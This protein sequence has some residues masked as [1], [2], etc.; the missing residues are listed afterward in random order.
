MLYT[1][2]IPDH[3]PELD[4]PGLLQLEDAPGVGCPPVASGPSHEHR[5][6]GEFSWRCSAHLGRGGRLQPDAVHSPGCAAWRVC[7]GQAGAHPA[8]APLGPRREASVWV[9]AQVAR[10]HGSHA[11]KRRGQK[12]QERK[13]RRFAFAAVGPK[14]IY[15][16]MCWD[17]GWVSPWDVCGFGRIYGRSRLF[18]QSWVTVSLRW[19]R[20]ENL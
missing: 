2:R 12:R 10:A 3:V 19:Q 1:F 7:F 6:R 16:R 4:R 17:S 13:A 14:R 9:C 20:G 18:M 8:R 5:L 11:V 15:E